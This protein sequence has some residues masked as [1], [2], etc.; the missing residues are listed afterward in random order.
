ME[1][2]TVFD[3]ICDSKIEQQT[4]HPDRV[5]AIDKLR[6]DYNQRLRRAEFPNLVLPDMKSQ[7][8]R[9]IN[10]ICAQPVSYPKSETGRKQAETRR[11][12][13]YYLVCET[14]GAVPKIRKR[15]TSPKHTKH[16]IVTTKSIS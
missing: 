8:E 2:R 14:H 6:R 7:F 11:K 10:N 1:N 3:V 4:K 12:S 13:G 5:E 9:E 15:N 16:K